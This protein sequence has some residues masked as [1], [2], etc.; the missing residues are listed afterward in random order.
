M[1]LSDQII[2]EDE[3]SIFIFSKYD[4]S[5]NVIT[6]DNEVFLI[7]SLVNDIYIYSIAI[8]CNEYYETVFINDEW[9]T[10]DLSVRSKVED[11]LKLLNEKKL[12]K[13]EKKLLIDFVPIIFVVGFV[14]WIIRGVTLSAIE[15]FIRLLKLMNV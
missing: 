1:N 13:S 6:N 15:I 2:S 5:V 10:T 12:I 9:I 3:H 14:F 11:Q 8:K 4:K 7:R